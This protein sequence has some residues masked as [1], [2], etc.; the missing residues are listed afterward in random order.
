MCERCNEDCNKRIWLQSPGCLFT[1]FRIIPTGG[2][3]LAEKVNT[4]TRL[5]I[6]IFIIMLIVRFKYAIHFLI[7]ALVILI[8]AYYSRKRADKNHK[9]HEERFRAKS[10]NK[11]NDNKG[12]G[13]ERFEVKAGKGKNN[14][15][16]DEED[17][18]SDSAVENDND[19]ELELTDEGLA[20]LGNNL[21][22]NNENEKT[23]TQNGK[24][25]PRRPFPPL[26]PSTMEVK[27]S[28]KSDQ[29]VEESFTPVR[30]HYKQDQPTYLVFS[31]RSFNQ[32][33]LER[34]MSNNTQINNPFDSPTIHK[35]EVKAVYPKKKF[36]TKNGI[37]Q[38]FYV[39][40]AEHEHPNTWSDINQPKTKITG[41]ELYFRRSAE[42]A[43]VTSANN[44]PNI[45]S[46]LNS[47][48]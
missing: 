17:E 40:R 18:S 8:I 26:V 33:K 13:F 7:I 45:Q 2:M 20:L 3:T 35:Q 48:F 6:I 41:S 36:Q 28:N 4:I 39:Q 12:D 30:N 37:Q 25:N 19:Q 22:G 23:T 27:A 44:R 46:R 15:R 11:R 42:I 29:M 9:H 5:I 47:I 21:N 31:G 38:G 16:N 32:S 10:S 14:E 1:D 34:E 43:K 24:P